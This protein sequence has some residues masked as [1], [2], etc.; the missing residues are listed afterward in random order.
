MKDI[1]WSFPYPSQRMPVLAPNVVATSQ[2]LAAQAGLSML[3]AGGNAVDA[4]LATAIALAVVEPCSNGI[5]SDAFALIWDGRKLYGFNGSGR[6]PRAWSREYFAGRRVMPKR[7]WGA[8]TTPGA[9]DAWAQIS[10]RFG[11]LRFARLFGPAIGYAREGYL[12]SPRVAGGFRSAARGFK[13]YP[14]I[15][16]TFLPGGR[17]TGAGELFRC[18]AMARTLE[19]IAETKG[20]AFYRGKLARRIIAH[21]RGGDG[22]MTGKDLADHCGEW[23]QPISQDYRGRQ[24]HEI[25]P[26]GQGLAALIALGILAHHDLGKHPVD[27]ADSVHLQ[28]E[29]MRLAFADARRH[30]GDAAAMTLT[31][32]ELLDEDRLAGLAATI[33]MDRTAGL[34]PSPQTDHGTVYLSAADAS[35]MMVSFIQ[36]NFMGFGS[37]IV[38]PNTGISLQ[39][40]GAGFRLQRGHPNCVGGG[41]RPYHTIIPGFVTHAGRAVMSFGVM[42]GHMQPQGHVQMMTRIF[43]YGQNPQAAADAPRWFVDPR[44]RLALEPGLAGTIGEELARRGHQVVGR[45]G[46]GGA[47]LIYRLKDGYC[48]ASEPRND[49][50]AVGF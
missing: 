48:A 12:V 27:S 17:A 20:E 13:D 14:D 28:V 41:K 34:G 39:N 15:A 18:P 47:Q 2:P 37:G 22:A 35:G 50:Q 45:G 24:L 16:A 25:P 44:G 43:D 7:G 4:A 11:K 5:G 36:S 23:V 46:F 38:V 9:V 30:L 26:N 49:G 31:P 3:A 8:V 32:A 10:K 42:G 29:A 21:S 6:A 19:T 33:R 1:S 40:R